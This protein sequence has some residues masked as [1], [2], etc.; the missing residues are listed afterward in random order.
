MIG[1]IP[2]FLRKQGR[3]RLV[4]SGLAMYPRVPKVQE[5]AS[6][7][8]SW[9]GGGAGE[10]GGCSGLMCPRLKDILDSENL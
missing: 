3:R 1:H 7:E 9:G 10:T 8:L 5:R 6:R 4:K 2:T